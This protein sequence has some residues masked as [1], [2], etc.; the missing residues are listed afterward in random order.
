VREARIRAGRSAAHQ[1]QLKK[2][3]A[4]NDEVRE[5]MLKVMLKRAGLAL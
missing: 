3:Q 2:L 4:R 5:R 1:E